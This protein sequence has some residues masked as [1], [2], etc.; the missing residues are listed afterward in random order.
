MSASRTL[1]AAWA[2][3]A[4][5][6]AGA[7]AAPAAV[8]APWVHVQGTGFADQSGRR[9]VLRGVDQQ[10]GTGK[11]SNGWAAGLG[12][13]FIRI[14]VPWSVVEPTAPAGGV[15]TY[16]QTY[17]GRVDAQVAW[18]QAHG[19]DVLL[20]F[21]QYKWSP[22]FGISGAQ[23][24]PGWFYAVTRAGKYARTDAGMK[25]A[26]ADW[27]TDAAGQQAYIRFARMM[28]T[29]YSAYPNVVGYE[30]FNEPMVG[31]MGDSH[32]ATQAV[33]AWEAPVVAA[34]RAVDSQRAVVIML[35][36]GGDNGLLNADFS[37]FGGMANVVVDLH[38]YYNGLYGSGYSVDQE[39]WVPSWD[40][41]HNQNF[42]DYHG[43][44]YAQE[45][46]LEVAINRT[47]ALGVPLLIG[48]WGAQTADT[49]VLTFQHQMVA[50]MSRYG[51]SWARWDMGQ[52][53]PFTLL[54]PLATYDA[55][56]LD[57]QAALAI[58]APTAGLAPQARIAPAVGGF[59]QVGQTLTADNG[60]WAGLPVPAVADAW[61]RCDSL[62]ANCVPIAGATGTAY[63]ATTA[64]L[65]STLRAVVTGTNASGAVS[66]MT[67][68]TAPVSAYVLTIANLADSISPTNGV[69]S[70]TFSLNQP[71]TTKIVI[72]NAAGNVIKNLDSSLHPAGYV[73]KR[74]DRVMNSGAVAPAGAYTVVVTATTAT[75]STTASVPL[76]LP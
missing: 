47:R 11:Q 7:Q 8:T 37:P 70:I 53:T 39:T 21:H 40:A 3:L 20:D 38:D 69:I 71:A 33:I 65:G 30:V 27:W 61:Q 68:V 54:D 50:V 72:R 14:S 60:L 12:A 9:V 42:L 4:L 55:A 58:P 5:A 67:A 25:Q 64:D 18:Y 62:G 31:A 63:T 13:N 34:L 46:D 19:I 51:L 75:E 76:Q 74:W 59:A 56:G 73:L 6:L 1:A 49:G 17:L 57:L 26:M 66:A 29:R 28:A 35:R 2:G 24:I 36:G 48:E 32:A 52:A 41:T 10:G 22:Y 16:S 43:T 45:Q 44:E 23:G 15:D